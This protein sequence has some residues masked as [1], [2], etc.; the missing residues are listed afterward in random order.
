MTPEE[1]RKADLDSVLKAIRW[2]NGIIHNTGRL[3]ETVPNQEVHDCTYAMLNLS[4]RLA[5]RRER[6]RVEP[7]VR[8]LGNALAEK[9][10]CPVPT[11]EILKYHRV[12]TSFTYF[13]DS[14]P[15]LRPLGMPVLPAAPIPDVNTMREIIEELELKLKARDPWFRER[16]HLSAVFQHYPDRVFALFE[17][18]ELKKV[19]SPAPAPALMRL[20]SILEG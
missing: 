12:K 19:E 9:T 17:N 18:G 10:K 15:Y 7:E 2:R 6:L 3:P 13:D 4:L 1:R 5:E 20:R 11:I 14:P 16:Q 8:Q